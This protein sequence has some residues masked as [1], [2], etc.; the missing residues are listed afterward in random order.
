MKSVPA[1]VEVRTSFIH[2]DVY[3]LQIGSAVRETRP[4]FT[5]F[6][7]RC[8]DVRRLHKDTQNPVQHGA[9]TLQL[10]SFNI[11]YMLHAAQ[12]SYANDAC[13]VTAS[14]RA[15]PLGADAL[16]AARGSTDASEASQ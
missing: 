5:L 10:P 8:Y 3:R 7:V 14:Y 16:R 11:F 9:A 6:L 13:K 1:S 2:P 15:G 4:A 12:Q